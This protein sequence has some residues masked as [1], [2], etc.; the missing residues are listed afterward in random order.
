MDTEGETPGT[1]A[2]AFA[3]TLILVE[4]KSGYPVA[5]SAEPRVVLAMRAWRRE[6]A[7]GWIISA[8]AKPA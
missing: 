2:T 1:K 5:F 8:S 4:N 3:T 7:S 6:F